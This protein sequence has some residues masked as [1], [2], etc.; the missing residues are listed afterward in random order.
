MPSPLRLRFAPLALA[1][2][3]L[4]L[5]TS[6]QTIPNSGR[7]LQQVPATPL[8][9]HV[10]APD[11]VIESPTSNTT[12]DA[13]PFAVTHLQ[14][15]GNTIFD[16]ATLHALVADG[17]GKTLTLTRLNAL[18]Q[19][20]TDYYHAHG[21]PLAR[22]LVPAQTLSGG[23]V[24][25]QVVEARY[26]Q[27]ELANQSRID[28]GLLRATLAP[29]HSG[30]VVTQPTLD[31][32]LLLLGD[33]PGVAPHATLRPGTEPGTSTLGVQADAEPTLQGQWVA[34]TAGSRYTGRLRVGAYLDINNPMRHG[35]QLSLGT[36]TSGHG[37]RYGRL[38]YQFTLNGHGTRLGAAY[39][40]LAYALGGPLDT[41]DAHGNA[42]VASAWLT[43]PL[44]RTQDSRLDVRLQFDR[45]QLRD[46]IDSTALRNDRH[47][48]HWTASVVSQHGDAW[49]G[50]GLTSASLS[51]GHGRLGFANA[52]AAAADAATAR[53]QGSYTHWNASLARLQNLSAATRVYV[54]LNGQYSNRNLDSSEQFLLGGSNSVRGYDVSS[55]AG[56]SGWLGTVELRHDL[57]FG[58][59]G[60]CEGSLF[61]DHGSL[62]VNAAPWI[63]GRNQFDLDGVGIGFSWIGTRHWQAQVQLATPVGATPTLLGKRGS[64]RA[65]LQLVRGF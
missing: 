60:R 28:D 9:K 13:T 7:I 23:T 45:K 62:R 19:W 53:T 47:S 5:I 8:D 12:E 61:V 65:W 15:E 39:S 31:T 3:S 29:L 36:L 38:G 4:P 33:L 6:A 48:N 11:V 14:V 24:R 58:C 54:S 44:V 26:D 25:L 32:R 51:L 20:I 27:I 16:N 18:A 17:E 43:Q 50:G 46:R 55:I 35:D 1:C 42:G 64:A 56:A 63:A 37:L 49:G 57:P 40:M 41:L 52:A 21:Y 30:E 2:F 10:T 59:G 22:A 34:D